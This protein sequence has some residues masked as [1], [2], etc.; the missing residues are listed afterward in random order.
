ML[1]ITTLIC[2]ITLAAI[3]TLTSLGSKDINIPAIGAGLWS[4]N[5]KITRSWPRRGQRHLEDHGTA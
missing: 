1:E 5:S 2:R 4:L 3:P